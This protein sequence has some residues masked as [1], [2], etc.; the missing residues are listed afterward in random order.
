MSRF[1]FCDVV[2]FSKEL[3]DEL[4]DFSIAGGEREKATGRGGDFEEEEEV[5]RRR[6]G[7]REEFGE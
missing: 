4:G 1:V 7:E 5:E 6:E 3:S 2:S